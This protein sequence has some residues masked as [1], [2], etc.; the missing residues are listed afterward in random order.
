MGQGVQENRITGFS[1]GALGILGDFGGSLAILGDF[2]GLA[3]ETMS[4]S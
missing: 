1:G 2:G 4:Q 3:I